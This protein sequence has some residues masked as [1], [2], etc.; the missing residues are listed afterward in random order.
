MDA[1]GPVDCLAL[2]P[3]KVTTKETLLV[4]IGSNGLPFPR[5]SVA[6]PAPDGTIESWWSIG[7]PSVGSA[8]DLS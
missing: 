1:I 4:I 7:E 5:Y 6:L 8:K 3:A 2:G